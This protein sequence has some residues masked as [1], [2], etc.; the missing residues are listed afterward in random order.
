MCP[1]LVGMASLMLQEERASHAW[2]GMDRPTAPQLT[3]TTHLDSH[4]STSSSNSTASSSEADRSSSGQVTSSS[5]S[6]SSSPSAAPPVVGVGSDM[7]A[8]GQALMSAMSR[9][10]VLAPLGFLVLLSATPSADSAM[11]Y[12][13]TEKLEFSAAFLGQ[14]GEVQASAVGCCHGQL[15]TACIS[16]DCPAA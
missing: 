4:T 3:P 9:A 10:E 13:M 2:I 7:V 8:H 14:V 1:L 11:F 15:S 12:Y 6:N 5:P 16:E